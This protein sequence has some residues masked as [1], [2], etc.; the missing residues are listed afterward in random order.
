MSIRRKIENIL[1]EV[2][3]ETAFL[4]ITVP[5]KSEFGHYATSVALR[6]A[7][8]QKKNP[9]VVAD[10]LILKIKEKA[11]SE[12]FEK[13]EKAGPGFINFWVAPQVVQNALQ[14]AAADESFGE[15]S[16]LKGKTVM[17]EF[18]DPNPFKLFHLGHLMPNT[19]GES[20]ARIYEASGAKVIRANYQGDVGL[21]VAKTIWAMK[22][23]SYKGDTSVEAKVAYL[24]KM[25]AEGAKIYE[26]N[27]AAKKE[28]NRVNEQIYKKSD[29]EISKLYEWGKKAS[30]E[31]FETIY[32]RLGT[33]FNR[34][35][36]ESE[37][38]KEGRE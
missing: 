16:V 19:I 14:S 2:L 12:F 3:G 4:D 17:I 37:V 24:G 30:L 35:F 36:F 6:L 21:H 1:L 25:Y 7:K 27:E 20:L 33:K 13:I 29:P 5:E 18:T 31:Y 10:E 11:P 9:S 23:N 32:K 28:I 15:N 22:K 26:E 38:E 34:Y 8:E